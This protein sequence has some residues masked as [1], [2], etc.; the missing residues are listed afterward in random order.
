MRGFDPTNATMAG[1]AE[2]TS[3]DVQR[4]HAVAPGAKIVLVVAASNADDHLIAGLNYSIDHR[5]GDVVSMS[6]GE[7]ELFLKDKDGKRVVGA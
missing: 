5:L 7:S 6:F 1:W 2:E 3:L 4:A